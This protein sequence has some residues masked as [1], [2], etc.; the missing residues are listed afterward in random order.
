M[1]CEWPTP[2][3]AAEKLQVTTAAIYR[4]IREDNL[5]YAKTPGGRIRICKED[6]IE[7]T[8]YQHSDAKEE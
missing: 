8:R 5:P 4:W 1:S 3:Q 2:K 6:L 7:D